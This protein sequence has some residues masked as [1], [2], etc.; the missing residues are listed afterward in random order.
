MVCWTTIVVFVPGASFMTRCRL[1]KQACLR[2]IRLDGDMYESTIVALASLYRK[3][4]PGGF[5]I[6]DDRAVGACKAAVDDFRRDHGIM[7]GDQY[8]VDWTGIAAPEV[9][10]YLWSLKRGYSR[11]CRGG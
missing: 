9:M 4:S 2:L 1:L 5:V 8:K 3:L 11:V 10:S 7:T 6:I